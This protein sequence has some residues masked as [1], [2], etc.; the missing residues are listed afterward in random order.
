MQ[1]EVRGNSRLCIFSA[2]GALMSDDLWADQGGQRRRRRLRKGKERK[3][4]TEGRHC[5]CLRMSLY[6]II[7]LPLTILLPSWRKR[8]QVRYPSEDHIFYP[9]QHMIFTWIHSTHAMP[10]LLSVLAELSTYSSM[11]T[12][13]LA[14]SAPRN[15]AIHLAKLQLLLFLPL[16]SP[17]F[18]GAVSPQL[19]HCPVNPPQL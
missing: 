10:S 3:D 2:D 19:A 11:S 18:I 14:L 7:V 6:T 4:R 12:S 17:I 13:S 16:L 15:S 8:Q 5:G 9:G 1:A